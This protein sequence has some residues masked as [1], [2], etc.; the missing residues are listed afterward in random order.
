V[1]AI[2]EDTASERREGGMSRNSS[3][4]AFGMLLSR[5]A[6]LVRDR[7]FAYYFGSSDAA[8]VFRAAFRIPNLLQ[9]LFGEGVLSAAFIPVYVKLLSK[10][11]GEEAD[12]LASAIFCLLALALSVL[13]LIGVFAAPLLISLIAPGFTGQKLALAISLVRILFPGAA[14]L[15]MSAWCLGILNSHR[16]FFISYTAP[17]AWNLVMIA[18]L[19]AF[20]SHMSQFSLA[21]VLAWGSVLGSAVQFGVQLPHV[22]RLIGRFRL[23][24][25]LALKSVRTVIRSFL[26]VLFS[27]GV[28]QISAYVDTLIASFLPTGALAGL[29]YAQNLYMLPVSLFGMSVSAAELPALSR[30]SG[31]DDEAIG[32]L[33]ARLNAGLRRIAFLIIPSAVAFFA[34]GDVVAG[35]IYQTGRFTHHDAVYVWAILAGSAIGLLANTLGRLYASMYYALH[36][37]RTPLNYAIARVSLTAVL[38]YLSALQL[39]SFLGVDPRWG[40]AGLAGSSG[41]SG[42]LEFALLKHSLKGRIGRTGL[43]ASFAVKLWIA[44]G[45]GAAAGWAVKPAVAGSHPILLAVVVLGIYGMVYFAIAH[46]LHVPEVQGVVGKVVRMVRFLR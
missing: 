13:V 3:L 32:Y 22:A 35:A 8:D 29:V 26:P 27:R 20:G 21:K 37:T 31:D 30:K 40:V 24:L 12:G 39:P 23:S 25:G 44:A 6:G 17:V 1:T 5:L 28:V 16:R 14:L 2:E 33:R 15:A 42:W 4:V 36:D 46:I 43:P 38:G 9:N 45:A 41:L 34:L 18:T 7:V 11:G 19:I 10:E